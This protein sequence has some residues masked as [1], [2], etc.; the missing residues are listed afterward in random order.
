MYV[1]YVP[2]EYTHADTDTHTHTETHTKQKNKPSSAVVTQSNGHL[3]T[4]QVLRVAYANHPGGRSGTLQ[5]A[6][7]CLTSECVGI[8][9]PT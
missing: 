8:R 2:Q 1:W 4:T 6:I 3:Y 7:P 9:S 5:V